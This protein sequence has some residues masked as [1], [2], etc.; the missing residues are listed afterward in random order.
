VPVNRPVLGVYVS[1]RA[2][3]LDELA[4]H[5]E[6]EP[7]AELVTLPAVPGPGAVAVQALA[8]KSASAS[9]CDLS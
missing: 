1:A 6:T 5:V 7:H 8:S 9:W 3:E 4:L 2:T